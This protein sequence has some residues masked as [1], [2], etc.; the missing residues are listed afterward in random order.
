MDTQNQN[1]ENAF[2]DNISND[3]IDNNSE[4]M[5][6]SYHNFKKLK[7]SRND[8]KLFGI[9]GG[10][11]EYFDIDSTLIRVLYLIATFFTGVIP[12]I[13]LYFLLYVVISDP[14]SRVRK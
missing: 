4:N 11:G 1:R 5:N 14:H 8:R 6:W 2:N 3:N 12:G 13:V 7:L 9:C 10:V